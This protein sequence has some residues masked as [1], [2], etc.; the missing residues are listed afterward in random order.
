MRPR[1]AGPAP[2]ARVGLD[3]RCAPAWDCPRH[4]PHRTGPAPPTCV[5]LPLRHP[6][7]GA[8]PALRAGLSPRRIPKTHQLPPRIRQVA[9][10]T[11]QPRPAYPVDPRLAD[12][13]ALR[14]VMAP[15]LA[16][17][18]VL[19]RFRPSNHTSDGY[20]TRFA[21]SI[22]PPALAPEETPVQKDASPRPSLPKPNE[23]QRSMPKPAFAY[24]QA[25]FSAKTEQ[26]VEACAKA[27]TNVKVRA[28]AGT[29]AYAH[30]DSIPR[31]R[32]RRGDRK[33]S[34]P[35]GFSPFGV[36]AGNT[37]SAASELARGTRLQLLRDWRME[38][39]AENQA[40]TYQAAPRTERTPR[41]LRPSRPAF[42]PTAPQQAASLIAKTRNAQDS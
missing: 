38:R 22:S 2:P 42:E 4:P 14:S 33:R 19:A 6:P 36:G 9:S 40:A 16:L 29:Y 10:P 39:Q 34:K 18:S 37:A 35:H 41:S 27:G 1:R 12:P 25:R 30:T 11:R 5:G 21:G 23:M 20:G 31:E 26:N 15:T 13:L 28:K 3:L 24:F 17:R 32:A 8:V 7:H